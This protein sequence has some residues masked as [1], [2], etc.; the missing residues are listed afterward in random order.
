MH[1]QPRPRVAFKTT[2]KISLSTPPETTNKIRAQWNR[3]VQK[4]KE[5]CNNTNKIKSLATQTHIIGVNDEEIREAMKMGKIA[6]TVAD[7]GA[8][9]SI[10]TEDNPSKQTGKPSNKEFI[11]PNG[12][13]VPAK[14]IAEYPFDV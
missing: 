11:L 1:K 12:E 6:S 2:I 8:T 3:L 5:K 4:R 13:V 10:G 14:E 7:S 9:S